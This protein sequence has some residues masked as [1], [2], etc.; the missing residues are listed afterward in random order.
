MNGGTAGTCVRAVASWI[1]AACVSGLEIGTGRDG[2]G[3]LRNQADGIEGVDARS[4]SSDEARQ[5]ARG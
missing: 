2:K 4:F 3:R 5:A 1:G